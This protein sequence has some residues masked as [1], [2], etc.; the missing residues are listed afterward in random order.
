M[1]IKTQSKLENPVPHPALPVGSYSLSAVLA[2]HAQTDLIKY[3]I[4]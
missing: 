2:I 1:T 4:V 3:W